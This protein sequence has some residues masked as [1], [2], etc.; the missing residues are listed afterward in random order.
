[1]NRRTFLTSTAASMT[2]LAAANKDA[3]ARMQ[4]ISTSTP[5]STSLDIE[6]YSP[7]ESLYLGVLFTWLE[8]LDDTLDDLQEAI[9]QMEDE[10]YSERAKAAMLLPLGLWRH[11]AR[12]TTKFGGPELF[13][14]AHQ[15][16]VA[17]FDH[18]GAAA[19]IFVSGVIEENAPAI[20]LGT[21][22]INM[23]SEEIG[24]MIDAL[25]FARP[26]RDKLLPE[27]K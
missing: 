1:M 4:Y 22:L 5:T 17:A 24:L 6:E 12:D 2:M 21:E 25:P 10:H 8:L 7:L 11:V 9:S 26:N 15:H 23:A 14:E 13:V 16:T 20:T 19:E 27:S 3:L 18:L